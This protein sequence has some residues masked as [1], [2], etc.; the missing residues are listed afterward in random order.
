MRQTEDIQEA[1]YKVRA[2]LVSAK[3]ELDDAANILTNLQKK[4][5][6]EG[7]PGLAKTL[8]FY[9]NELIFDP[10]KVINSLDEEV[11]LMKKV[12]DEEHKLNVEKI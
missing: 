10:Q 6:A 9:L 3:R 7:K 5:E 12:M 11:E 2:K 8:N 4:Y 1:K